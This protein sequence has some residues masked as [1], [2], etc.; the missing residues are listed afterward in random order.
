MCLGYTEKYDLSPQDLTWAASWGT[1]L[2]SV[3]RVSAWILSTVH[4]VE[5]MRPSIICLYNTVLIY[6]LADLGLRPCF[7]V[8]PQFVLIRIQ[9]WLL[10][11]YMKIQLIFKLHKNSQNN[12]MWPYPT[13]PRMVPYY[14]WWE[15]C[16]SRQPRCLQSLISTPLTLTIVILLRTFWYI[17]LW[18]SNYSNAYWL[19][20]NHKTTLFDRNIKIKNKPENQPIDALGGWPEI[21]KL[22]SHHI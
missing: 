6:L 19:G 21:K 10:L 22:K 5:Y 13:D 17:L 18:V 4:D 1:Y 11:C 9:W 8:Y 15:W 14:V 12:G 7:T 16:A 2:D 20:N 3:D